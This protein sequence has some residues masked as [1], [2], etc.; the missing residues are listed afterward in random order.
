[1][2]KSALDTWCHAMAESPKPGGRLLI[3]VPQ[4]ILFNSYDIMSGQFARH[5][6]ISAIPGSAVYWYSE[7][8]ES[9]HE[10]QKQTRR[11]RFRIR[12]C[13]RGKS[14]GFSEVSVVSG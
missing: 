11:D 4:D 12:R 2:D 8:I 3:D 13:R 10:G 9:R 5:L 14:T 1:L 7:E 6:G